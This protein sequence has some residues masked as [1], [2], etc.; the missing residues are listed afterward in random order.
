MMI[1][2]ILAAAV[3]FALSSSISTASTINVFT[4]DV[5]DDPYTQSGEVYQKIG[6]PGGGFG[7]WLAE[8]YWSADKV[9]TTT[10]EQ[11]PQSSQAII[12][13][14]GRDPVKITSPLFLV[15]SN[16]DLN[17][18]RSAMWKFDSG[19]NV[20]V[21]HYGNNMVTW[22]FNKEIKSFG[23]DFLD[24][25]IGMSDVH[26]YSEKIPSVPIPAAGLLFGSSLIGA[27]GVLKFR[28]NTA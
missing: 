17:G 5:S 14:L 28:K 18:V 26:A 25:N 7:L 16:P 8:W 20:I 15:Y 4:V 3:L 22:L 10:G 23:V 21:L 12:N 6:G 11:V 24:G 27:L 13:W 9:W 2:K 19:V 1:K